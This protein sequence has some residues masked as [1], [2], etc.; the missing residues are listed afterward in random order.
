MAQLD[1]T[2]LD[3]ATIKNNL[4]T[5]LQAQDEFS[6]Y[7][8]EGSALSVLLDTL[9]YNTHYNAMLAH[10]VA[11]ESFLDTAIKRSS[12]VSL[13]KA[14]GYTPRSARGSTATINYNVIP[15]SS[16]SRTTLDLPRDTAFTSSVGGT[17]YVFYPRATTTVQKEIRNGVAGFYFDNVQIT[18]GTRVSNSFVVTSSTLSG[19]FTIPNANVDT[20]TLRVRI[21]ESATDLTISTYLNYTKIT[22]VGTTT[23]AYFIEEDVDGL[24]VIRF[25]DDYI[26]KKLT[27]GNIVIV[28]Y[29][30]TN[31]TDANNASAFSNATTFISSSESKTLTVVNNSS[32]GQ[33][34]EGID[35]IRKTAPR[36]N[37][38]KNR[39]VTSSDYQ[40][41]ILA[42]NSNIQSVS[43]WGGEENDP[44]IYGKV[45]ISLD[46]IAGQVITQADKDAIQTGIIDPKAPLGILA[47]FVDP[48]YMYIQLRVG[49]EYD[50][51]V[52]TFTQS[53]IQAAVTTS[54]NDYFADDLNVLNKNFYLSKI[55]KYIKDSS[56]SIISVNINPKL[57]KRISATTL[58]TA[59]TFTIQFHNKLE[60]RTLHT[61]WFNAI[62]GTGTLKL[63]LVDIPNTGVVPP[64]YVGSGVV[65][66]EDE[67]GKSLGNVGTVNYDT[68]VLTFTANISSYL[69]SETFVRV[70]FKP[71]DN[72]K[73]IKTQILTRTAAPSGSSAVVATPSK[74]TVLTLDDTAFNS[75]TGAR[76]GLEIS[77][78]QYVEN[79]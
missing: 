45:F 49:I 50:P 13:A 31:G 68:G 11:N 2:E 72:V 12:V 51:K 59:E 74:N 14:L 44:P 7:N 32:G 17:N 61:T 53:E 77:I 46:P 19:P 22:D 1:V 71:H 18:E 25:G 40:S 56:P 76:K 47:E 79:D 9:A 41:L 26:G 54:I 52:T 43:V 6:D 64:E 70:N 33:N 20:T 34:K 39:A 30:T 28:D 36:Y 62:I 29:I 75:T 5:Y 35:S 27:A 57:Q 21:Q 48:S 37:Q 42:S 67:T 38:T 3:F 10:L 4:K 65:R 63:K 69:N 16:D 24:Y 66:L 78:T 8:F 55:H 15:P 23:Q 60:P 73:D 58:G